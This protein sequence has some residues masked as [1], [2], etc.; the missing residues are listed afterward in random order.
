MSQNTCPIIPTNRK[1]ELSFGPPVLP[2]GRNIWIIWK[3]MMLPHRDKMTV[4]CRLVKV[5]LFDSKT[6]FTAS[7][8]TNLPLKSIE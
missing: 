2:L 8:S 1:I 7:T 6:I 5:G 4:H 3:S